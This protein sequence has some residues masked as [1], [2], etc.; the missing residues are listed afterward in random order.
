MYLNNLNEDDC[1]L[2][3]IFLQLNTSQISIFRQWK[4]FL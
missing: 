4:V 2:V 1:I 3:Q